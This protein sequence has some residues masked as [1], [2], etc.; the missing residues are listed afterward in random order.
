[1]LDAYTIL[2][3][4]HLLTAVVW[5]GGGVAL[6]VLAARALRSDDPARMAATLSDVGFFGTRIIPPASGILL[7]AGIG[8]VFEADYG[9]DAWIIFGL[10]VWLFSG[11]MGT[12]FFGPESA[13]LRD[14]VSAQGQTPDF[15]RRL[16]RLVNLSRLESGLLLLVV[17]DMAVKPGL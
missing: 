2:L 12:G 4:V 13:R 16:S 11:G 17:V 1:M 7:L 8:L 5:V 6:N 15:N 3:A 14:L 10:L 9:F